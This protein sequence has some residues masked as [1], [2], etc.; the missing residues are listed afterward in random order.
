MAATTGAAMVV[1]QEST[2]ADIVA[3]DWVTHAWVSELSGEVPEDEL[4]DP[5]TLIVSGAADEADIARWSEIA[6]VER[7]E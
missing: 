2:L 6:Q 3:V 7:G 1:A 4:E 5:L